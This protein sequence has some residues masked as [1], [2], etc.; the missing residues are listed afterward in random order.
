MTICS[1]PKV[2][3]EPESV[4]WPC[5]HCVCVW[6]NHEDGYDRGYTCIVYTLASINFLRKEM[7]L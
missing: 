3:I 7:E 1:I 4:R 2:V 5:E 6:M